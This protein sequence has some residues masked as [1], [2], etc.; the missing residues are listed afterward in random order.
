MAVHITGDAAADKVLDE[1]RSPSW[2]G[3]M[4]DQQYPMDNAS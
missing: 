1:S 4:L 2:V 3:M